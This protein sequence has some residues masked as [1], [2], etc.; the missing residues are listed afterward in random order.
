MGIKKFHSKKV[1]NMAGLSCGIVGLASRLLDELGISGL[2]KKAAVC[3]K[4]SVL[5]SALRTAARCSR[6]LRF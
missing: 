5:M 3:L 2:G 1:L 4:P 6:R